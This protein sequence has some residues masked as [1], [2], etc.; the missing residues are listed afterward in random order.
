MSEFEPVSCNTSK[1]RFQLSPI[2]LHL[3]AVSLTFCCYVVKGEWVR[4]AALVPTHPLRS[5]DDI[6]TALYVLLTLFFAGIRG[7]CQITTQEFCDFV[8]GKF[9]EEAALCSQVIFD[10]FLK[11]D[12]NR[13]FSIS[14]IIMFFILIFDQVPFQ[15]KIHSS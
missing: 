14:S 11:G 2:L 12:V 5:K 10:Y 1:A 15:N 7:Q 3:A 8:K 9:H 4:E 6:T 13:S